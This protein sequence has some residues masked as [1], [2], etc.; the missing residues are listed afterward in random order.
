MMPFISSDKFEKCR[1]PDYLKPYW[2]LIKYCLGHQAKR[3]S[4]SYRRVFYLTIQETQVEKG[5]SQR[6]P[7]M[8]VEYRGQANN[9]ISE[10]LVTA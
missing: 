3:I 9:T 5:S 8:H 4:S 1:L 10:R 2:G 6:R 7:G